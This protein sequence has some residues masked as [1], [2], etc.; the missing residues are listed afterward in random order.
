MSY[1]FTALNSNNYITISDAQFNPQYVGRA[2]FVS[3][4][5]WYWTTGGRV[6]VST[7]GGRV[8]GAYVSW[9]TIGVATYTITYPTNQGRPL[10]FIVQDS[11]VSYGA[12]IN[13]IKPVGTSGSNTIWNIYVNICNGLSM[14]DAAQPKILVFA[15]Y[16]EQT[17]PT[18]YGLTV[19]GADGTIAFNSNLKHLVV[20]TAI[21]YT[22]SVCVNQSMGGSSTNHS[23]A[24]SYN[25]V[26]SI[27]NL[28][29]SPAFLY[30]TGFTDFPF[31]DSFFGTTT[32]YMASAVGRIN[33][34]NFESSCGFGSPGTT[35]ANAV[36][37]RIPNAVLFIDSSKYL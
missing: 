8:N 22:T 18:G 12:A 30:Q 35:Y 9:L 26:T 7:S 4:G 29:S 36:L 34:T 5:W 13:A 3:S 14:T 2:T 24:I 1:G 37:P 11:S 25:S 6:Y 15:S 23:P 10:P 20:S 32:Y 33:G 31:N 17:T 28:P 27:P 16:P 19:K 21:S